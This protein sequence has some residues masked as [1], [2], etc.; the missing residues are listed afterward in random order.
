MAKSK[1]GDR[2]PVTLARAQGHEDP[3]YFVSI[4]GKSYLIP[5][6]KTTDVP[7][8]VAAEIERSNAAVD[9]MYDKRDALR[10]KNPG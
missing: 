6:G 4:N 1:E 7:P 2:I 9:A 10:A 5:K 8:E 3:N